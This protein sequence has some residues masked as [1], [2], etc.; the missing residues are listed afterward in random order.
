[1]SETSPNSSEGFKQPEPVWDTAERS[2]LKQQEDQ[3][4]PM[5]E[6]DQF[7]PLLESKKLIYDA[8]K[9]H[10]MAIASNRNETNIVAL[11]RIAL[12]HMQSPDSQA[13]PLRVSIAPI[14]EVV[15][16]ETHRADDDT[17]MQDAS[18]RTVR[19]VHR[20]ESMMTADEAIAEAQK[21]RVEADRVAQIAAERHDAIERL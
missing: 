19:A 5:S 15:N 16:P 3:V 14:P 6:K 21:E 20:T 1:M 13:S 8:E 11:K 12:A 2:Q 7:H 4:T 17:Y 10:T 9:A 18:K